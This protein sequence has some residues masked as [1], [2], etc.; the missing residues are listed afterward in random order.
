[1]NIS[2]AIV[3]A[4]AAVAA[5]VRARLAATAGVEVHA[6]ADDGR[7]IISIECAAD[8]DTAEACAAI[9]RLDGVLSVSLVYSPCETNPDG[10]ICVADNPRVVPPL[11]GDRL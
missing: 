10:E 4:R 5:R 11:Q 3:H 6:A 9:E 7:L 8:Q 1:M 2:S